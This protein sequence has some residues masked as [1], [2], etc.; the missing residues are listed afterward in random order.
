MPVFWPIDL[1]TPRNIALT[2][3]PATVVGN[4][5][6]SGLSQRAA[7]SAGR[8][9]LTLDTVPLGEDDKV[10]VWRALEG[11]LQGQ[12]NQI[13][14]PIDDLSRAP[15]PLDYT[16]DITFSDGATFSDGSTF[17]QSNYQARV[18]NAR[19]IGA[20]EMSFYIISGAKMQPGQ[21]FSLGYRLYSISRIVSETATTVTAKIWP[22]LREACINGDY[23]D[24]TRPKL[25]CR[26][27]DDEG[28]AHP[29]LEYGRWTNGSVA[30]IE[31]TSPVA[32]P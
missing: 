15:T 7:S 17:A 26:L 8:W 31:D 4:P 16:T 5:A 30:F 32:D 13:V 6:L 1:L 9:R 11:L 14:I 18:L 21:V 25:L 10:N 28:M 19:A 29:P 27:A 12:L 24:F 20:T 2:K 23:C 3:A 22:P